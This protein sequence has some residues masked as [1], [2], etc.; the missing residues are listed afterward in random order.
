M[1]ISLNRGFSY[2]GGEMNPLPAI[3]FYIMDDTGWIKLHRKI[4]NSA[5]YQRLTSKQ[6]D[7]MMQCLLLANHKPNQWYFNGEIYTCEPGEF[8]TSL[9]S[10]ASKCAKDVKVQSVRTALLVLEK[11]QFLTNKSTKSGRLIKVLQW[12]LYQDCDNEPNNESNRQLTKSQQRANKELTTNKNDKNDKNNIYTPEREKEIQ[13]LVKQ[14]KININNGT[15][16][17]DKAK[18]HINARYEKFTDEQLHHAVIKFFFN[19]WRMENNADKGLA[20][21]FGSDEQISKF[22]SLK[23]DRKA[24]YINRAGE[25]CTYDEFFDNK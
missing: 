15:V 20:W 14:Y 25:K 1:F 7:V 10:I 21:F 13:I 17:T 18:K 11:W 4:H 24:L 23:N 2:S 8:V 5:M 16:L 3:F 22:L 12:S 19:T 9:E 6:R